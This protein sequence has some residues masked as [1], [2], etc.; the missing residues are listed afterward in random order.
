VGWSWW[1]YVVDNL[2]PEAP[3]QKGW[4]LKMGHVFVD[5]TY[6]IL[7]EFLNAPCQ[8]SMREKMADDMAMLLA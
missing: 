7:P 6:T 2:A 5:A 8:Y 3:P 4:V 1:T